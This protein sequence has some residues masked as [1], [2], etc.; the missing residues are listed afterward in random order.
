MKNDKIWGLLLHM[1]NSYA[2]RRTKSPTLLFDDDVWNYTIENAA[3]AGFNTIVLETIDGV[4]YTSHPEISVSDAWTPSKLKKEIKKSTDRGL[5]GIPKCNFSAPHSAWLGQYRRLTSTA[6]YYHVCNDII[7]ELYELFNHPEYIH[8]GMDEEDEEH[9]KFIGDG[10]AFFRRGELFWHDYR[11]LLECVKKTGAKPWVW[12]DASN[13]HDPQK[14]DDTEFK[15]R[16]DLDEVMISPWYYHFFDEK[17]FMR[18]EDYKYDLTPYRGMDIK[19][20]E[21]FPK[22]R[23]VRETA[24]SKLEE[25]YH[26]IPT[27]WSYVKEN[28]HDL[29]EF[30]AKGPQENMHG[31]LVSVWCQLDW[32]NKDRLDNAFTEFKMAKDKFYPN[33]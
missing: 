31:H 13:G 29:M 2:T 8:I 9:A 3:K 24:Y 30:F 33:N 15:K 14:C 12:Y 10:F 27:S 26:Y 23:V 18:I 21:E 4:M 16:I 25:G 28:I 1:T 20:V 7:C 22:L 32:K 5:T 19:Y 11:F 17:K 6:E